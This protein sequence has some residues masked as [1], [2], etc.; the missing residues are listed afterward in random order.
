M[1]NG[2]ISDLLHTIAAYIP[3]SLVRDVLDNPAPAP[4]TEPH[5]MR[6]PA[7]VL[8]G[9]VSGFT[10]LTEALGQKGSEGPEELTRLLNRYF[11]WMI[12]F[13]EAEGGEVV[14]F[15]GDALTAIFPAKDESLGMATR[16]AKQAADAM[17]FAMREFGDM[18][19]SVGKI[20]LKMK[21]AIGAGQ[22]LLTQ[23]GGID[24]RWEYVIAGDPLRQITQ[25]EKPIQQGEIYLSPEAQ[26]II[27]LYALPLNPLEQPDWNTIKNPREVAQTLRCYTPKPVRTW[28]DEGL[29][30]WLATLRPM[31]VLFVSVKG[32]DYSQADAVDKLHNFLRD[33]QKIIYYYRG[34]L[35]R[36]TIDDKG[37]VLLILF[38]APPYSHEDDPERAVR[39]ALDLQT[40]A[41][42]HNLELSIGVTTGRVFAGPVGSI[43]RREYTVMGDTVNLA[44]R[45]MV[46]AGAGEI[47]CNYETYRSAYGQ[48]KFE[49]LP[50]IEVKG[51]HGFIPIYRPIG[52]NDLQ[53]SQLEHQE[54]NI[55]LV[56]RQS[57]MTKLVACLDK[58]DT[59]SSQI[60]IIEGEAGI[61]KSKLLESFTEL[62][63]ERGISLL[64][65]MGRSIE[66][67]TPYRA[68]QDV[69]RAYFELNNFEQAEHQ[70]QIQ[71]QVAEITPD[72]LEAIAL[73]NAVLPLNFGG[74]KSPE[75]EHLSTFLLALLK[76]KTNETPV[77]IILEDAHWLDSSSWEL[78]L[79]VAQSLTTVPLLLVLVMR[80]LVEKISNSRL[81]ELT[82]LKNATRLRLDS[83]PP[84]ETLTLAIAGL[85]LSGNELPE[86]V[87]QLI[88]VRAGGNPFFA[89]EIF[90]FLYDKGYITFKSIADK[91]RCL[92][93]GDINRAAQTLPTTIQSVILSRIDQLSPEKQLMLRVAAVIGQNFSYD[94][95]RDTLN[96]LT[97]ISESQLQIYLDNL[98]H[99]DLIRPGTTGT[100]LIYSFKHLIIREVTYQS[101]LFDRRRRLHRIVAMW[102]ESTYGS[103]ENEY[104]GLDQAELLILYAPHLRFSREL[105]P[106]ADYYPLLVYHWHQA[107]DDKKE[108]YYATMLGELALTQFANAEAVGYINRALDLTAPTD[109]VGRYNLLVARE[110]VYNLRGQ[111]EVQSQDLMAL[112]NLVKEMDDKQRKVVVDLRQARYAEVIG[113][114]PTALTLV[115]QVVRQAKQ[116][117]DFIGECKGSILWGQILLCQG[118]YKTAQ[119]KL[120][121]ALILSRTHN[122]SYDEADTLYHLADI[123]RAQGVYSEAQTY[124]QEALEICQ[125]GGY[126]L[127][128]AHSLT[129]FGLILYQ[130]GN[131]LTAQ[132]YFEQAISI[133][134]TI[135]DK[136]G[137]LHPFYNVGLTHFQLG[138]YE[139]ARDYFE[140]ALDMAKEISDRKTEAEILGNLSLTYCN[141]GDYTAA[142]SYVGQS[143]DIHKGIGNPIGEAD[144]LRK[145]GFINYNLGNSQIAHRYC[146]MA[147]IIQQKIG[148]RVGE[149]YTLTCLGHTLIDQDQLV[150]A[151][152]AYN[153]ALQ[154]H[155]ESKLTIPAIDILAGL[156]YINFAQ[157]AVDEAVTYV[158][159][160]LAWLKTNGIAGV[161][162]PF[163]VYL[164]SFH[165]LNSLVEPAEPKQAQTV[166]ITAYETLQK[167]A[168]YINNE[169]L[170]KSYLQKI[171]IH[172]III[173]LW[174]G[175][176]IPSLQHQSP[177]D[178]NS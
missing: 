146:D 162:S 115:Q 49:A 30:R 105:P 55:P 132:E 23:V 145:F 48:M 170:K 18:E 104:P 39:C 87:A 21:I 119:H 166:L 148:D 158:E 171:R 35:P 82:E 99:L 120:E 108:Q 38:G 147:L 112:M 94:I 159:E 69:F 83:L 164:K 16:R 151:A 8:F 46:V 161:D 57:E 100:D 64:V 113:N 80:P 143:L 44:A 43:I 68:W 31:S 101:L 77:A 62:I 51:K 173:A 28:I 144:A 93:N 65:G 96:K 142:R 84:D 98:V 12:S 152:E 168:T 58:L 60:L 136:R 178:T 160:I 13:I 85:G 15:G 175:Q 174:K 11:S 33:A 10:P 141:L 7:A 91:T 9:D 53:L 36:L 167:Q 54:S 63:Q 157:D 37:T 123:H 81:G 150:G 169:T 177:S 1:D 129:L 165:I 42:N 4:P 125:T 76:A 126:H 156:A 109:L 133:Y 29:H 86:I 130:L 3:S 47:Y 34:S 41:N 61:G 27:A 128:E 114:Y 106:L 176:E 56:G 90:Y 127:S 67:E 149:R 154:L 89:E 172:R 2:N 97:E 75:P 24:D 107:E 137:E 17:L 103:T 59:G 66:Q 110:T 72:F 79:Q 117:K 14:K 19:S 92:I 32:I 74:A 6:F 140:Q 26:D 153:K 70:K 102:Y 111:R 71:T 22:I 124:C 122:N 52:L 25:K 95:L 45:L 139:K 155:Q 88:R 20:T 73:L 135:G 118:D 5:T 134:Y 116:N 78:V 138:H 163:W 131:Y 50:P 40:T 121:Q